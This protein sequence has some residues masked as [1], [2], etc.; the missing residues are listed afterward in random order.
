M[1]SE[2][3]RMIER[4][5]GVGLLL[6]SGKPVSVIGERCWKDLDCDLAVQSS[7]TRAIDFSHPP[8]AERAEDFVWTKARVCRKRH[9]L[10]PRSVA[11][12]VSFDI[13]TSQRK[14]TMSSGT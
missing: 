14:L 5:R 11:Q 10:K 8:G 7:V 1:N 6:E 12:T 4:R 13:A 2:D 9:R 3:I